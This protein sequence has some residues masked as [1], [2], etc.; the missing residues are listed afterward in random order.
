VES[1]FF[2]PPRTE[3]NALCAAYAYTPICPTKPAKFKR[4]V[5]RLLHEE[6]LNFVGKIPAKRRHVEPKELFKH[7]EKTEI[8]LRRITPVKVTE[9]LVVWAEDVYVTK[10][11]ADMV[12]IFK[13]HLDELQF[14]RGSA[15]L[16]NKKKP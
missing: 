9:P 16:M 5:H 13:E 14:M 11:K 1:A 15:A 10:F 4:D 7:P 6:A 8:P 3:E 2:T 12:E